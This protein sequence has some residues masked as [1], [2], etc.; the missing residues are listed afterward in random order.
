MNV[1][2][3]AF[4]RERGREEDGPGYLD[5]DSDGEWIA[6]Y[7]YENLLAEHQKQKEEIALLRKV[8]GL[9]S[10][11]DLFGVLDRDKNAMDAI[12][13]LAKFDKEQKERWTH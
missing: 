7:D 8:V 1:D 11:A 6:Y 5:R 2:R 10:Y 12:N 13:A 4:F 3:Y 9:F